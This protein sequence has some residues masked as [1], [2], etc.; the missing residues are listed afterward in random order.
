MKTNLLNSLATHLRQSY[1]LL[2]AIWSML[3]IGSLAWNIHNEKQSTLRTATAAAR[4]NISKD[5][6]FRKWATSH[7]GVY[8]APT[9]HTPPNPYLNV[10]DRDVVTTSGKALTLMNPAYM[11]RQ[12]QTDFPGDFGTQSRIASLD[13]INPKN[14]ADAWQAKALRSFEQGAK[15]LLEIQQLDG[16]PYLRMMLPFIVEPP[17]ASNAMDTKATSWV[18]FAVGS[19]RPFTWD[20]FWLKSRNSF[21]AWRC[22]TVQSG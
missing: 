6:S 13:P 3:V 9:E 10:P 12:I 19:V 4:A 18:I 5:M 11:L 22:P 17:A 20:H 15:E 21:P 1:V 7:G 16:Q 8:V 14:T 2:A